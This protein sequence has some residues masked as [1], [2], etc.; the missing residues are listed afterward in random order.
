VE[1]GGLAAAFAIETALNLY[2]GRAAV[3]NDAALRGYAHRWI[4]VLKT[5]FWK[6]VLLWARKRRFRP[7]RPFW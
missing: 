4:L 2:P 3:E 1:C 6:E 5:I 7:T